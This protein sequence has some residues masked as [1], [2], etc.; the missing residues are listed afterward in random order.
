VGK[1]AKEKT[2]TRGLPLGALFMTIIDQKK[3]NEEEKE[4][5]LQQKTSRSEK[6]GGGTRGWVKT[7][8]P[9]SALSIQTG[10]W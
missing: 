7:R 3:K 6:G 2:R 4:R 9:A 8:V 5:D 10:L 1:K